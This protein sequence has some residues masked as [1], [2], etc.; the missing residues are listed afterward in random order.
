MIDLN[1]NRNW[2]KLVMLNYQPKVE[3]LIKKG[4]LVHL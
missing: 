2:F 1:R 4:I 3:F